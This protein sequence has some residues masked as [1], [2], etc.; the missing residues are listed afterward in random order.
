[1]LENFAALQVQY[2]FVAP[3]IAFMFGAAIGS[4]L[5]V[6]VYRLPIMLSRDWQSQA[7]EIIDDA[8]DDKDFMAALTARMPV[9]SKPFNLVLPSSKCPHCKA[10]IRPW[11]N[12]P[13]LGYFLIRGHCADC[14][15]P[16]S[17]RYPLVELVTALLSAAVIFFLGPNLAGLAGCVLTWALIALALIDYD[18]QLLPDDITLPFL[19]LGLAVNFFAVI[20]SFAGAFL[21]ACLGYS[22]LWLVYQGFRLVTGK[23]G[24][25]Y[26]DFKMLAMLGAWLGVQAVPLIII[27][28]S[29]VGAI[30]GG[31]MIMLGRDKAKPIKFGPFLALA[32]FVAL[33]W[34]DPIIAS[35]LEFARGS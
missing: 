12:I 23:E 7:V 1:M 6:V 30:V 33:L 22:I 28:S 11:H 10:P 26:G 20:T 31:S 2:P 32:G 3:T 21:G 27:L 8:I 18:T 14:K 24:M 25:G 5:N 4:F 9:Y 35:Y 29:F 17:V 19:W 34:G 15:A 13:I 16:I